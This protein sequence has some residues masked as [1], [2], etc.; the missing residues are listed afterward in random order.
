MAMMISAMAFGQINDN[1]TPNGVNSNNQ[2]A[3]IKVKVYAKDPGDNTT[4]ATIKYRWGGNE[5]VGPWRTETVL[6]DGGWIYFELEC[7]EL[8]NAVDPYMEYKIDA[9]K[10]D[11]VFI[12]HCGIFD[13]NKYAQ[14][15]V[16]TITWWNNCGYAYGG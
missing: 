1:N 14:P 2:L 4:S 8:N 6:P 11:G 16:L 13:L 7:L 10:P 5:G 3:S 15:N 9:R 12:S